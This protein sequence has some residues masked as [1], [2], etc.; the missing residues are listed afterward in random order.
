[1]FVFAPTIWIATTYR[2]GSRKA[3]TL[4]DQSVQLVGLLEMGVQPK[5]F[6]GLPTCLGQAPG[7][8]GCSRETEVSTYKIGLKGDGVA[9]IGLGEQRLAKLHR[10]LSKP[11]GPFRIVFDDVPQAFQYS[12]RLN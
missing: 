11:D 2:R 12:N 8:C 5:R 3:P 4:F 1:M 10:Q 9:E 6:L 7:A